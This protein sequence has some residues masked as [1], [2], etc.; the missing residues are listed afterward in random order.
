MAAPGEQSPSAE[1]GEGSSNE[2][3]IDSVR[4]AEDQ[5]QQQQEQ[6]QQHTAASSPPSTDNTQDSQNTQGADNSEEGEPNSAYP[7]P[8]LF[9]RQCLPESAWEPDDSAMQC[10]QCARRFTLF[11]RRHHCR[12]CGLIFCVNC[13][14]KRS[15]LASPVGP[16]LGGYYAPHMDDDENTPLALLRGRSR[17]EGACWRFQEHRV[18]DPCALAVELLEPATDDSLVVVGAGNGLSADVSANAHSIF[19]DPRALVQGSRHQR[20]QSSGAMHQQPWRT[21][22]PRASSSSIRVCPVCDRDWATIWVTMRRV[23]GEGWQETQERHIR[24]CIEDTSAEMQGGRHESSSAQPTGRLDGNASATAAS[25]SLS[26]PRRSTGFLGIFDRSTPV[27]AAIS[28]SNAAATETSSGQGHHVG[29]AP[30][31]AVTR[32]A[33]SPAGVKYVAYQLTGDTPLLGEECAICFDDFEPGQRVARLNC[34][35]TYHLWCISEWL[36]RTPACPVH[37]E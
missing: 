30:A 24:S 15:L 19:L 32:T 17:E 9:A 20:S 36:Q 14:S 35:C 23:P 26:Q 34:L 21:A 8:A 10:R 11:L 4:Q 27:A 25:S 16:S 2:L 5:G 22:Q 7:L 3:T 18:C 37:Y 33:R 28:V 6:E 1:V 13:S 29:S 31:S 12:R